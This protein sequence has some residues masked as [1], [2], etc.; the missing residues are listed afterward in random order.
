VRNYNPTQISVNS[1]GE[2]F[3]ADDQT[4]TI[5]TFDLDYNALNNFRLPAEVKSIEDLAHTESELLLLDSEAECIH[6]FALN[7]TYLGFYPAENATALY[8]NDEG[9]WSVSTQN[10]ITEHK[11]NKMFRLNSVEHKNNFL[12]LQATDKSIYLITESILYRYDEK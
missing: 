8:A 11:E 3:F 9:I 10:Y 4:R 12:D 1:F 6:R 7:G 5:Y 2:I